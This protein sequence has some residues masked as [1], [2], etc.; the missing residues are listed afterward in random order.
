M[1]TNGR[2]DWNEVY[3]AMGYKKSNKLLYATST[4]SYNYSLKDINNMMQSISLWASWIQWMI[5]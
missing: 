1:Q 2:V 4:Y 5:V 3:L